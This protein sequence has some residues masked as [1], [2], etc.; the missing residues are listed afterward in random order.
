MASPIQ[1]GVCGQAERIKDAKII[2]YGPNPS[3]VFIRKK[4]V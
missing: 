3:Y 2:E 1:T 4:M